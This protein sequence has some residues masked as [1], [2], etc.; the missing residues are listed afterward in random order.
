MCA[1]YR[2]IKGGCS[3]HQIRNVV[4]EELLLTAIREMSDF[5]K[6]YE[7]EFVELLT[8]KSKSETE[9]GLRDNKRELEQSKTR[10]T[11]LDKIIQKLYEDNVEGKISDERF[12]KLSDTY[13]IEIGR[14]SCRERV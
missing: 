2:K 8:K 11:K 5:T 3:S 1:T 7:T 10:I 13:E 9:K 14:A 6:N 12:K 4:V